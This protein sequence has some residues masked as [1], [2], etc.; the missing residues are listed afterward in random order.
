MLGQETSILQVLRKEFPH[1]DTSEYVTFYNLRNFAFMHNRWVTQ[2][3]YVHSKLM[4]VDD[5]HVLIGSANI[6]ARI[7]VE[8]KEADFDFR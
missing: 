8:K 3:I 6:S 4:I 5:K 1:I 7:C 2:Q